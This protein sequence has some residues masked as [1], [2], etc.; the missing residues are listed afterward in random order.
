MNVPVEIMQLQEFLWNQLQETTQREHAVSAATSF[1]LDL[2]RG[3]S[4]PLAITVV[5]LPLA[6]FLY[7]PR[8]PRRSLWIPAFGIFGSTPRFYTH[9]RPPSFCGIFLKSRHRVT[10]RYRRHK[11]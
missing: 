1:L 11:S 10:T 2:A 5:L 8:I 3:I 6:A 4:V 7:Q 9:T